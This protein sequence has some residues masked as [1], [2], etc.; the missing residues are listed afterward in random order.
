MIKRAWRPLCKPRVEINLFSQGFC[1][2]NTINPRKGGLGDENG[3][4][5][6]ASF[7]VVKMF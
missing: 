6:Q 3:E 2:G 7:E 5:V 1:K 4:R